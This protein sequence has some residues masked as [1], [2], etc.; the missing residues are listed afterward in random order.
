MC[1]S[2]YK[3]LPIV[4]TVDVK[5][6]NGKTFINMV[7]VLHENV[8]GPIKVGISYTNNDEISTVIILLSNLFQLFLKPWYF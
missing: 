7:M 4:Q 2:N 8:N 1:P 6:E 3:S 5:K